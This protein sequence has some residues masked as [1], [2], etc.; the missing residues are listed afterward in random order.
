MAMKFDDCKGCKFRRRKSTEAPCHDCDLGE[1]YEDIDR[2]GVDVAF[3][4]PVTRFG[5]SVRTDETI[6]QT[7]R[8]GDQESDDE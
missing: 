6:A 1:F 3:R 7:E 4:D 5:E 8:A 2:P